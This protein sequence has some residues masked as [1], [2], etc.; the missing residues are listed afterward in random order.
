MAIALYNE[1]FQ[2][3]FELWGLT[4]GKTTKKLNVRDK[5]CFH[6]KNII[7]GL[8]S[9]LDEVRDYKDTIY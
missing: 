1:I 7:S 3:K 4:V 5:M 8:A 2:Y 9:I 6:P